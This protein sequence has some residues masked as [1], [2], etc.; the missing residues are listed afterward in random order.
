MDSGAVVTNHMSTRQ[1]LG[2]AMNC[3]KSHAEM[4]L[5]HERGCALCFSCNLSCGYRLRYN[6]VSTQLVT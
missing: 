3:P 2:R 4:T 1:A 5:W 6:I